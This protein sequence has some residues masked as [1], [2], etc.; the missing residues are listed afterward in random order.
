MVTVA[1]GAAITRS[2][3][4]LNARSPMVKG[5]ALAVPIFISMCTSTRPDGDDEPDGAAPSSGLTI[6][7]KPRR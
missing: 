5:P 4:V 6:Q 2:I 7:L 3:I 1:G